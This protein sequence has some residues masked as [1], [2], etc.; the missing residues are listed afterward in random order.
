[1]LSIL[2]LSIVSSLSAKDKNIRYIT[3]YISN[4]DD[5]NIV[6]T[7]NLIFRANGHVTAVSMTPVIIV[8]EYDRPEGFV[9]IK[10][11]K[12]DV[13]LMKNSGSGFLVP[14]M[15]EDISIYNEGILH[16]IK[17]LEPG[18]SMV[19]LSDNTKL[20]LTDKSE[21]E[22]INKWENGDW[23][24]FPDLPA[25]SSPLII[26]TRTNDKVKISKSLNTQSL[27]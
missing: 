17:E 18:K 27:N 6:L 16:Q 23:V 25:S 24:I 20:F 10:N 1:M 22:E 5:N 8:L 3:G 19:I 15:K 9:F 2:L 4:V 21:K 26:N 12:V 13:V 11:K 7:N 14:A